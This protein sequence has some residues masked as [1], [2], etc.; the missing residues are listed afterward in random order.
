MPSR[1][2]RRMALSISSGVGGVLRLW[3]LPGTALSISE[4]AL[5]PPF[6]P[7][8]ERAIF[9]C[10]DPCAEQLPRHVGDT[11][12]QSGMPRMAE[13]VASA[14]PCLAE[15]ERAHLALYCR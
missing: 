12:P 7:E 15:I 9:S 4:A 10:T 11:A 13:T 6:L 14:T 8:E 1:A 3:P 2:R 5:T